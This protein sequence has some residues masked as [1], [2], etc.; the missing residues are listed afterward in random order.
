MTLRL[1]IPMQTEVENLAF[2]HH[3]SKAGFIR[4]CIRQGIGDAYEHGTQDLHLQTQGGD[5]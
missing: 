2:D 4:R 5:L 1:S 3:L